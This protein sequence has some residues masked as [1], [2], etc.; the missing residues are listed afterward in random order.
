MSGEYGGR[1]SGGREDEGAEQSGAIAATRGKDFAREGRSDRGQYEAEGRRLTG[2]KTDCCEMS[3]QSLRTR[4]HTHTH[5]RA[6]S[7]GWKALHTG[8]FR[9]NLFDGSGYGEREKDQ[10]R[11]ARVKGRG[12]IN[13]YTEW[14]PPIIT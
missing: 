6:N 11:R 12:A 2:R 4:T 14:S 13:K 10:T 3:N 8:L 7:K 1:G 5:T 9:S